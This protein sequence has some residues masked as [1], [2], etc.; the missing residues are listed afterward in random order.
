MDQKRIAEM[1]RNGNEKR[2]DD[3]ADNAT[4]GAILLPLADPSLGS[5]V[6]R[7]APSVLTLCV[8]VSLVVIPLRKWQSMIS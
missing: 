6:A 7:L 1:K 3:I 8:K 5:L 2:E 4:I